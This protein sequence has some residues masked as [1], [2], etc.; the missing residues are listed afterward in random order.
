M[1]KFSRKRR[2]QLSFPSW[3]DHL[4][5]LFKPT[6]FCKVQSEGLFDHCLVLI[7]FAL[8]LN[9]AAKN[10]EWIRSINLHL[11]SACQVRK[12]ANA[13][14]YQQ[15]VATMTILR[16]DI[17]L[18]APESLECYL[19]SQPNMPALNTTKK[20]KSYFS[21]SLHFFCLILSLAWK[22]CSKTKCFNFFPLSFPLKRIFL[23]KKVFYPLLLQLPLKYNLRLDK[24]GLGWR[25]H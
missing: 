3:K 22:N 2:I 12:D 21:P 23:W 1:E 18:H 5:V 13:K 17:Y 7:C 16:F 6:L 25:V 8:A 10:S 15:K 11:N 24:T 20:N 19:W 9:L 14:L 4:F